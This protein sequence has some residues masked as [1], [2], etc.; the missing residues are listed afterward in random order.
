MCR[1]TLFLSAIGPV[2]HRPA[3]IKTTPPP[4]LLQVIIALLMLV[5]FRLMPSALAPYFK[6]L[7]VSFLND[8]R[9]ILGKFF[10]E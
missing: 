4:L 10:Q 6:I 8:V 5:V 3:G 9:A 2:S 7:N 1:L